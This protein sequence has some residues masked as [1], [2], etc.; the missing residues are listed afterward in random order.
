MD[1]FKRSRFRCY[2][3][4]ESKP[5]IKKIKLTTKILKYDESY[6][7]YVF[8]YLHKNNIDLPQCI[9]CGMVLAIASLKPNK[10]LRYHVKQITFITKIEVKFFFRKLHEFKGNK[11]IIK[12]LTTEYKM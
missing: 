7:E 3:E 11:K 1:N 8:T 12:S 5:P 4:N 9:I 10:L 2:Y 6:V